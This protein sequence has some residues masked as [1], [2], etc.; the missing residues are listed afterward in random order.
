MSQFVIRLTDLSGKSRQQW[1]SVPRSVAALLVRESDH[2]S[3]ADL[4]RRLGR[5]LSGLSQAASRI[6][7]KLESDRQLL[8]KINKIE[9][10]IQ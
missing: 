2:I 1:I 10:L 9:A 5:D 7:E 8:G 6:D 4:S 3:L